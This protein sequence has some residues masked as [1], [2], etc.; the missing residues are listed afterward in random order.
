M[1]NKV[2]QMSRNHVKVGQ[3]ARGDA[4][5]GA[6]SQGHKFVGF[7]STP[8]PAQIQETSKEYNKYK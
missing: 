3:M 7:N 6:M 2:G 1:N 4:K 8:S 5:M